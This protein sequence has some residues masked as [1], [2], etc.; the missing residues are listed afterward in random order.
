MNHMFLFSQLPI[1]KTPLVQRQYL[2]FHNG[3]T[4]SMIQFGGN[5]TKRSTRTRLYLY[6]TLCFVASVLMDEEYLFWHAETAPFNL[7]L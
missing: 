6:Y 2:N 7:K 5:K 4:L 3:G 1:A